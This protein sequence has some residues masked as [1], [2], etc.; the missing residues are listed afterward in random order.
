MVC[1]FLHKSK[2]LDSFL[3]LYPSNTATFEHNRNCPHAHR[4]D[5]NTHAFRNLQ[6]SA[7]QTQFLGTLGFC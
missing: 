1:L 4:K 6:I 2:V 3:S 5:V 7:F